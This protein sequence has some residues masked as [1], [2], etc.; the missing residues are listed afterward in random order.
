MHKFRSIVFFLIAILNIVISIFL[1]RKFAEIGAALGTA[2]T[3]I[4]GNGVVMN[5]Y[6]Q[7]KIGLNMRKYWIE[8]F[9]LTRFLIIP[10]IIGI[11]Y[12]K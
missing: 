9:K 4:L 5:Y 12:Y 1:I 7:Y 3:M 11:S 8:I 2:I 6:Y 10:I